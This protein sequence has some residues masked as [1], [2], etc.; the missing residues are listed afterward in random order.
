MAYPLDVALAQPGEDDAAIIALSSGTTSIPKGVVHTHRSLLELARTDLYL[1]AGL[2]PSD[3]SLVPLSTAF[4]GCY[5]GWFPFLNAGACAVFMERFDIGAFVATLTRERISHAFLTPTLWRRV[6]AMDLGGADF[7][8]LRQ[9]GFGAEPMD[10]PTLARLR[11]TISRNVVQVY[12]STETGAGGTCI[13]AEEMVGERL[14][15]V[16]RPMLNGDLRVVT[17]GGGPQEEVAAGEIGEI[18]LSSPSLAD[19][20]G[21]T[22]N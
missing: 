6:L 10:A 11:E 18:L 14:T 15:S 3:R 5:N 13:W 16:G 20:I 12:G 17:P 4:I 22:P 1:Y 9:I 2:K 19:R 21:T 7:S 8:A